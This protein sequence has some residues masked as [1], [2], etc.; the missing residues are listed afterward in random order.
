MKSL[1]TRCFGFLFACSAFVLIQ[2][3]AGASTHVGKVSHCLLDYIATACMSGKAL[4]GKGRKEHTKSPFDEER[5]SP[6][7][8][9]E[10]NVSPRLSNPLILVSRLLCTSSAP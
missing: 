4:L 7:L 10:Y 5:R 1:P 6:V 8:Q 2:S 3:A 9:G